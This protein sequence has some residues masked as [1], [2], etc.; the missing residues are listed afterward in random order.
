MSSSDSDADADFDNLFDAFDT[1]EV[2]DLQTSNIAQNN[3]NSHGKKYDA[4]EPKMTPAESDAKKITSLK[5]RK[6]ESPV[7]FRPQSKK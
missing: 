4:Y 2:E 7:S 6:A 5:K 1:V 3:L